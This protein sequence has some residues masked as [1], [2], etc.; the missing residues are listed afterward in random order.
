MHVWAILRH[1]FMAKVISFILQYKTA[2][3]V[4]A[5]VVLGGGGW[6]WSANRPDELD[7]LTV[8][9]GE[10]VQQVSISGKVTP[11]RS[12]DL[13]FS[14]GGRVTRV[15]AKVGS[16][17]AMGSILAEVENGD[18]RANVLQRE[19]ALEV[20]KAKLE[21]LKAG[22]RPEE[23]AVAEADVQSD[24]IALERAGQSVID[25]IEDAET[26]SEDAVY[27][28]IDK[29]F[30][31]PRTVV[32]ELIFNSLNNPAELRSE[33]SRVT[34]GFMLSSWLTDVGGLSLS[35]DLPGAV[36]DAQEN[37]RT[38]LTLLSDLNTALNSAILSSTF[39]QD[40]IDSHETTIASARTTIN[41]KNA[42]L[43]ASLT[44]YRSAQ[45]N[46]DASEKNLTLKKAGTIQA[47]VNAQAAQVK[48]A[49][50]DLQNARAQLAKT[51]VTA[52]FYGVITTMDAKVGKIVSPNTS[53]ISMVSTDTYQI[54]SYI[55]EINIAMVKVGD[56]AVVTLDAYGEDV[57]F[58]A[59]LVSI[60][61]AETLRDGV[62]TYRGILQFT[63]K[64]AR[65]RSGMTANVVVTTEK[66]ANVLSVPQ[67]AVEER[68]GARYVRVL[69]G[70]AVEE[71]TV[72]IGSISS[73][74]EAEILSGL[75]AGDIVV[76]SPEK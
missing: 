25:A 57:P 51:L 10:F 70:S 15:N 42:A 33:N 7:T 64:D 72:T 48:S 65:I 41:T 45:A 37:M 75:S 73:R 46:L 63:K 29:L 39:D 5:V 32:P 50:A 30:S 76:L 27:N 59:K 1:V 22:T 2:L 43:T 26:A 44:S 60:D 16:V 54:E 18:L 49:E 8:Q 74:G 47:D 23:I 20:Q 67:G 35:S 24:R 31:N 53:E 9:A 55:P 38:L 12:V 3:I 19:A 52:P 34:V 66:K 58:A 40:D 61:P 11:S 68:D 62:A 28:K 69:I 21:A 17:V 13:G 14:Q 6:Y 4:A 56:T 36:S 71:R